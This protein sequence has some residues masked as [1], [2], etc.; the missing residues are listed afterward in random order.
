MS[1]QGCRHLSKTFLHGKPVSQGLHGAGVQ[2][3]E[4]REPGAKTLI[5]VEFTAHGAGCDIGNLLP[6]PGGGRELVNHLTVDQGGIHIEHREP[7]RP[8]T[9]AAGLKRDV[10]ACLVRQLAK[11]CRER[12]GIIT[13]NEQ[14]MHL[15]PVSKG[16][17]HR[18]LARRYD[19]GA[20]VFRHLRHA[21]NVQ[22]SAPRRH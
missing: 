13:A 14:D 6:D 17:G 9:C 18:H 1:A 15:A 7:V 3:F 2:T 11:Q 4:Q 16:D 5:K 22:F 10:D 8:A 19:P 21:A 12:L 20:C